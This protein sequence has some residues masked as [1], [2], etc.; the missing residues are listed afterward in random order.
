MTLLSIW[1]FTGRLHPVLVHLPI[2]I[3]L[4]GCLFQLLTINAKFSALRPA[5]PLIYLLGGLGAVFSSI[6]GYL[7]SLSGDY[8]GDM[9][10]IHQWLGISV[11]IVSLS[12]YAMC[13][14]KI[15]ETLLNFTAI[16]LI[17]LITL[18]GHYGGSLTHGADYL[19]A[20]LKDNGKGKAAIPAIVNVQQAVAYTHMIQPLLQNRCYNCHGA[21]KQKGKLRLDGKDLIIK[22]GEDGKTL[23]PGSAEES[24]LIKRLL[25]PPSNEDHMPPKEKP[26]L[27]PE[28]IEL[29]KW[30]VNQG[31]DFNRKVQDLKQSE[32]EKVVLLSFQTGTERKEHKQ[33]EI[34]AGK[35]TK[36]DATAIEK[37]KK[38]GVVVIPVLSTS[39]Y[40]SASFVTAKAS[41]EV[42]KLLE[43]LK[44][45]LVWLNL[46]NTGLNDED[47]QTISKLDNL[48]RINLSRTSITDQG[49]ALLKGIV[50]LQYINLVGT[51]IT[52]SGVG[53]LSV[54]KKLNSIYLYQT[55]IGRADE[56]KLIRMFG[57]LVNLDFGGYVVPTL[58]KDTIEVKPL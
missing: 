50:H 48:I 51:K 13:R 45:Q 44:K 21:E 43:P 55:G 33:E 26:Q 20:A 34:P 36:A 4:L 38:A 15:K 37:L 12:V 28:E 17:V 24:E 42:L 5:I 19:S 25:L 2:G 46:A 57:K 6:S 39:N 52:T 30:W 47:M 40:L 10:G 23:V 49:L 18:T 27:T 1:D 53:Q 9:V 16:F 41:P 56:V 14:T 54:L 22:G 32:K 58:E 35:V 8:D 7:L 3:L 31:A 11:S 29:L